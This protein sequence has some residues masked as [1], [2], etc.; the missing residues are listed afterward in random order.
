MMQH[1]FPDLIFGKLTS[2]QMLAPPSSIGRIV[3]KAEKIIR[4]SSDLISYPM[5]SLLNQELISN[6]NSTTEKK[7]LKFIIHIL[8]KYF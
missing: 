8:K 1:A 3:L 4:I 7:K 2:K 6:Y 5:I